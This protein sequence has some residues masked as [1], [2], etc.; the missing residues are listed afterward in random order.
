RRAVVT[1]LW[2]KMM[3]TVYLQKDLSINGRSALGGRALV[4]RL[5]EEPDDWLL[6]GRV[7]R[8]GELAR[9]DP[10]GRQDGSSEGQLLAF[11]A[12]VVAI[13]RGQFV[14]KGGGWRV[15]RA[16]VEE[17]VSSGGTLLIADVDV[18][19]LRE[20][21]AEY[22]EVAGFLGASALYQGREPVAGYDERRFWEG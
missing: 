20:Q 3:R 8:G 11:G 2:G 16:L 21:R 1:R 7:Y 19:I 22:R 15:D 13:E 6:G 14:S 9:L 10:L 12:P 17:F 5:R 4:D 18:N